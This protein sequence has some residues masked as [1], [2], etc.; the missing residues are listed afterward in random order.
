MSQLN[1]E[2]M[3]LHYYENLID[4]RI[5]PTNFSNDNLN[6]S[7]LMKRGWSQPIHETIKSMYKITCME[8][9]QDNSV[10]YVAGLAAISSSTGRAIIK[11]FEFHS[12]GSKN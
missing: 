1:S 8:I 4:D 7:K 9:S 5:S 11:C 2:H 12:F 6:H 10:V 3:V